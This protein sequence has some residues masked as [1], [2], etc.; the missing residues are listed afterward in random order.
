MNKPLSKTAQAIITDLFATKPETVLAALDKVPSQGRPEVIVPLLRA[1]QSWGD[2]PT[3]QAKI[4]RILY[5]LKSEAA[6]PE[7]LKALSSE[8]FFDQRQLIISAFWNAGLSPV[9]GF[10]DLIREAIKGDY[11]VAFEVLTVI[12]QMEDFDDNQLVEEA[13]FDIEEFMD[14]EPEAGHRNVLEQLRDFL[15]TIHNY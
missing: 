8:E 11:L 15:R 13:I 2:E 1:Y 7:L 14:E 12:E 4:T 5:E 6:I 3:I 10:S 9:D